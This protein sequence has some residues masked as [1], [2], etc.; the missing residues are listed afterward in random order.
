MDY[1]TFRSW[2]VAAGY[3]EGLSINRL[4]NDGDYEPAN[5]EWTDSITQ[6]NNTSRN[7]LITAFGEI[8]TLAEWSRDP[9]CV[10]SRAALGLRI[11]RR[12]WDP[13]RA[14]ITSTIKNNAEATHCP[15]DHEYTPENISWDGPDKSWR[16]CKTCMRARAARWYRD[17]PV[18]E[19]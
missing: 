11:S 2:A 5:C 12:G 17:G 6:Q 1:I 7:H 15:A 13:E 9:R 14:I 3:A 18:N 16:K 8:K 10:V 4:D 19:G